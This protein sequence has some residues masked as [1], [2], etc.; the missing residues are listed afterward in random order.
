MLPTGFCPCSAAKDAFSDRADIDP[1]DD[2]KRRPP[3][4]LLTA[5]QAA[6]SRWKFIPVLRKVRVR[7]PVGRPRT[8]PD[9]VAGSL[10][11]ASDSDARR[12]PRRHQGELW[13]RCPTACRPQHGAAERRFSL[14]DFPLDLQRLPVQRSS[15]PQGRTRP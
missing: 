10:H 15:R 9:A 3:A 6:D 11:A 5:G 13:L 2:R 12:P 7:G 8:R 4:F 1:A 14:A